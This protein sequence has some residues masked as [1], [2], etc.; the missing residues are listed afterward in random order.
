M[1]KI[2]ENIKSLL[3]L[4]K[5]K[6][7]VPIIKPINNGSLLKDKIALITGGNGGIGYAI[8]EAFLNNG[9]KVVITGTNE[10]KLIKCYNQLNMK[11]TGNVKYIILNV[12]DIESLPKKIEKAASLFNEGKIDI[13]VNSA[14][15]LGKRSFKDVI[16]K[17]YDLIMDVNTKGTFFMCQAMGK[18][19]I[20][21]KIKGHILNISSSSALR[22]AWTPYCMSKWA[23][24]G[25]TI[26]LADLLSPYGI[27]VNAIAPGPTATAMLGKGEG[28]S[29]YRKNSPAKRFIL[30]SE[31]ANLAVF[32][33]SDMGN[34]IIGDTVYMTAG[35]GITTL[36]N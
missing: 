16:E 12:L 36:H 11:N 28:D 21:K 23:I 6:K 30:P 2:K 9:C 22:P 17:E 5:G 3:Q 32:L 1:K 18:F 24:R 29:I 34:M 20:N 15:V 35:S 25:F 8:A 4:I 27:V 14:G 13:L 33:A 19:M 10:E 31:I 26:G 7:Y